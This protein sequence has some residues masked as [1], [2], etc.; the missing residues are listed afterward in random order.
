M[1]RESHWLGR[2][3]EGAEAEHEA[4]VAGLGAPE[5]ERALRANGVTAYRVEQAGDRIHVDFTVKDPPD[6]IR[7]LRFKRL[8]PDFWTWEGSDPAA[9]PGGATRFTWE[10]A[11]E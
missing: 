1:A 11:D 10:R 5:V 3:A 4:F 7:F 2:I 6:A 9:F 8:W